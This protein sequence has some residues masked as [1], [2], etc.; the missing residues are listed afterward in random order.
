VASPAPARSL[1]RPWWRRSG[2]A[3]ALVALLL[4][5]VSGYEAVTY[6]A[7]RAAPPADAT[8]LVE[9]DVP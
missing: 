9:T 6:V 8:V 3:A 2:A 1:T 7:F 4:L 5:G